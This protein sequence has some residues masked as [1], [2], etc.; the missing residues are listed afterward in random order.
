MSKRDL[1]KELEDFDKKKLIGLISELY[2]KNK[3]V[4]EYLD[5]YLKPDDS[6]I[7]KVYKAKIRKHYSL[8]GVLDITLDLVKKRL[9]IF[10]SSVL[11][12]NLWL[13]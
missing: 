12:L 6:E 1:K 3:S 10:V 4:K 11:H 8:R 2:D 13:T 9:V 7:L 5:Y